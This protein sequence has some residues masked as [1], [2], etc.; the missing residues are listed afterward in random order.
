[1]YSRRGAIARIAIESEGRE[2]SRGTGFLVAPGLVLTALHVVA[3]RHTDPPAFYPG[4]LTLAFPGHTS[5]A[6]A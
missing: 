5:S 4:A 3:D 6:Q 2:V 1:M